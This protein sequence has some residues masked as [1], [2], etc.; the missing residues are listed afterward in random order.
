MTAYASTGKQPDP[1]ISCRGAAGASSWRLRIRNHCSTLIA[2]ARHIVNID[3][4]PLGAPRRAR[5]MGSQS[6]AAAAWSSPLLPPAVSKPN[7]QAWSSAALPV[8]AA[9]AAA[10]E[11]PGCSAALADVATLVEQ[12]LDYASASSVA[13]QPTTTAEA[14]GRGKSIDVTVD[15]RN[16]AVAA[17]PSVAAPRIAPA[18][19]CVDSALTAPG[20]APAAAAASPKAN[21]DAELAECEQVSA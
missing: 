20:H 13:P 4:P 12:L 18:P 1:R 17:A 9:L 8:T 5:V 7:V 15:A 10:M 2:M 11:T 19:S 6:P 21:T 16:P 3:G 14:Y